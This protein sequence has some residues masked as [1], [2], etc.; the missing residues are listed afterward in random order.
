MA[1]RAATIDEVIERLTTIVD[2]TRARL[3]NA[4]QSAV[5]MVGGTS[6]I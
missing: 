3:G 1:Q 5:Y 2:E 4:L 6:T